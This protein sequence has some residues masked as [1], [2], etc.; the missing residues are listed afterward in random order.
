MI[1][2][3]NTNISYSSSGLFYSD[4]TW[5]HP[6]RNIDSTEIIFVVKGEVY[7]CENGKD[8][9]LREG[10]F[11]ILQEGLEH[12]GFKESDKTVS[13]YWVHFYLS[14]PMHLEG[15]KFGDVQ[16]NGHLKSI[17]QQLLHIS[18]TKGYS[19]YSSDILVSLIIEEL[20]F[21]K[22]NQADP[23]KPL[24][25]QIKEYIRINIDD[26]ITVKKV[27]DHFMYNEN[28]LTVLFKSN[29]QIGLKEYINN[30]KIEYAKSLLT[31]TTYSIKQIADLISFKSENGFLKYFKYHTKM[32]PTEYRNIFS[33]THTNKR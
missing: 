19:R 17:F 7:I 21:Q 22:Q 20:K 4:K 1:L 30:K 2:I 24:I 13:F 29:Y 10:N 28:Y 8:Y 14:N 26:N 11:L 12:Y 25:Q 3:N 27:A 15:I 23:T 32:T 16:D 9:V 31:T 6:R 18:N 33:N 5:I